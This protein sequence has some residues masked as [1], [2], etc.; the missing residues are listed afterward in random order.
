MQSFVVA[1]WCCS[2][3]TVEFA[4]MGSQDHSL[5]QLLHP[6][7][8]A[9]E[10]VQR[11][12]ISHDGTLCASD[13]RDHGDGSRLLLT[14]SWSDCQGVV[15]G[16]VDCFREYGIVLVDAEHCLRHADL[17]DG[18]IEPRGSYAEFAHT[19]PHASP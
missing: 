1:A 17:H 2:E 7:A 8:V 13:L 6:G 9:R 10:N 15:V 11:V 12:G 5:R 19:S 16:S 3:Q 18:A 4:R 14:Q